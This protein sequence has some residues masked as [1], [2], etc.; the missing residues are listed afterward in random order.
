MKKT[1]FKPEQQTFCVSTATFFAA[2]EDGAPQVG[3]DT[4][5]SVD[6]E[7]VQSRRGGYS[8]WDE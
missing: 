8:A 7:S 2:S 5:S 4:Q 6:A 3:I 1:Y